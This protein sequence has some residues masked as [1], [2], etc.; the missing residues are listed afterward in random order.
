MKNLIPYILGGV[1]L[2]LLVMVLMANRGKPVRRMDERITLRQR[3]KIPYGTAVAKHLLP[4]LFPNAVVH[5]DA[6]YPGAWNGINAYEQNQAVILVADF[7]NADDD[8]LQRLNEFVGKGNFV[9]IIARSFSDEASNFF[10]LN[11]SSYYNYYTGGDEDTLFVKLQQPGFLTD[12]LFTYPG[13][14]Y[15]GRIQKIQTVKTALLG[16]NEGGSANFVQLNKGTGRFFVHTSPL[17]F[18][19]Y[20]ILHKQNA[21]YYQQALSVIPKDVKA[22]VWNEYFLEKRR[23]PSKKEDVNWLGTLFNYPAFKWG[24]LTAFFTLLL[25]VLLGMRRNQ[26]MIPPHEKPTNDS[27]DFVKTL[28]RLYYDR[29]DHKNLAGKMGAYFLEHVRSTYK[30][31]THTLDDDFIQSLHVKSGYPQ[32][33]IKKIVTE[34][35]Q[36]SEWPNISEERLADFHKSLELFYQNT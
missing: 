12:S 4:S 20:F 30:I 33:E 19:N 27:L 10:N 36:F 32:P 25:Y 21:A 24:L 5:A 15:E 6:R 23:S 1:L 34:I 7:F 2:L 28:G 29:R 3:D 31:T 35:E 13:K 8:E 14:K 26:R 11:F 18:S 16:Q 22:V 9:F 17:A